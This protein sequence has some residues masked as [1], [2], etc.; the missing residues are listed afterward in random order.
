MI[1]IVFGFYL[2][3]RSEERGRLYPLQS[4]IVSSNPIYL[5][6][7]GIRFPFLY[8]KSQ[9]R[10]GNGCPSPRC[11]ILCSPSCSTFIIVRESALIGTKSSMSFY[12]T[13]ALLMANPP[14]PDSRFSITSS[15]SNLLTLSPILPA[16]KVRKIPFYSRQSAFIDR[17]A[18]LDLYIEDLMISLMVAV[19][20]W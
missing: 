1:V 14:P 4:S 8:G 20:C 9:L 5:F 3:G 11:L 6:I 10:F 17:R 2:F 19:V 15:E 12:Q 13:S 18:L 7:S 16:R